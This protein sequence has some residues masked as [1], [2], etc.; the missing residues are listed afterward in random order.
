MDSK[1]WYRLTLSV[2]AG[3]SSV[4]SLSLNFNSATNGKH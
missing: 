3:N 4:S 1:I 2:L